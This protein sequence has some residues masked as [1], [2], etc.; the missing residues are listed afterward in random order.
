VR[1]CGEQRLLKRGARKE[2]ILRAPGAEVE[3]RLSDEPPTKDLYLLIQ[4]RP[5]GKIPSR[6]RSMGL[7]AR[8]AE[9]LHW[10][11]EGKTSREIG[12][13]LGCA[14]ATVDKHAER[15]L[16]KLGVEN[17]QAASAEVHRW[18]HGR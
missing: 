9:V 18:D 3:I 8:E 11:A 14:S 1:W 17:R 10:L 4:E 13:I 12:T 15:I 7:T 5:A 16:K 2:F 6:L